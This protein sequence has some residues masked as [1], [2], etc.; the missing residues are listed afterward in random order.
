MTKPNRFLV[1]LDESARAPLVYKTAVDLAKAQGAELVLFQSIALPIA[2]PEVGYVE[3]YAV[4]E[5]LLA[6]ARASLE[7][8]RSADVPCRVHV[9][10][11]TPWDAICRIAKEEKVSLILV[12][13]HGYG[14]LDRLLGTTAA[15]VVNHADCSVLVVRPERL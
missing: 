4:A 9:E 5:T 6:D 3:P 1:C 15:K 13:S 12:G 14:G 11:G 2:P 10:I 7:S 8:M